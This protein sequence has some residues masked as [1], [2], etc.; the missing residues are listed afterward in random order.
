MFYAISKIAWF[1][2]QPSSIL[3]GLMLTGLLLSMRGAMRIGHRCLWSGLA[4]LLVAGLSPVSDLLVAPLE[5]RFSRPSLTRGTV[6]GIVILGGAEDPRSGSPR[7]LM[8]LGEA[9]ERLTE[10]VALAR[11]HPQA[12]VV[13]SGG[14]D[15][16]W[17][18][19]TPEA[20]SAGKLLVALGLEPARLILEDK[21]RNTVENA[22]FSKAAVTPKAG[23]TWLLVTSASHMPRAMGTFRA[24]GFDVQ[25]WPVDYRS[26][27]T[28]DPFRFHSN[29]GEGLRRVDSATKEYIGLTVYRLT[30]KIR[31]LWPGPANP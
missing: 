11:A 9:G 21:S 12:R 8:A 18:S 14:S 30:G 15:E 7:E 26:P 4:G 3:V 25:P 17:R 16:V 31:S 20:Q 23:D 10:A 27:E 24:A 13:F 19:K 6:A 22:Q 5:A 28:F 1:V 29:I 2:L